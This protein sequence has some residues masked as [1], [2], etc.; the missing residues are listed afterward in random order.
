ML[1]E[2]VTYVVN[3]L[4]CQSWCGLNLHVRWLAQALLLLD[5]LQCFHLIPYRDNKLT[6]GP[7]LADLSAQLHPGAYALVESI[8]PALTLS[9][10][11]KC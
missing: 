8:K 11:C 3:L 9:T 6:T 10:T 4:L 1:E 5:H 2:D 7:P